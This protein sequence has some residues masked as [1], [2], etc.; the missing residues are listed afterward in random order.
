MGPDLL[1]LPPPAIT[2]PADMAVVGFMERYPEF[3]PGGEAASASPRSHPPAHALLTLLSCMTEHTCCRGCHTGAG[4]GPATGGGGIGTAPNQVAPRAT[5]RL[6]GQ[7]FGTKLSPTAPW[8]GPG[9]S[10]GSCWGELAEGQSIYDQGQ[11]SKFW[12]EFWAF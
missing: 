8:P 4:P 5:I 7:G 10:A 6:G 1:C 2:C 12:K 3:I 9:H 11:I